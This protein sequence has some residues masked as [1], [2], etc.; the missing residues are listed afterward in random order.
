MKRT[1]L[2]LLIVFL[3][4]SCATQKKR[5][6]TSKIGKA[7]HNITSKYNRYFNADLLIDETIFQLE[8]SHQDNYNEILPVYPYMTNDNPTQMA[9]PMDRAIEKAS[10]AISLHRPSH[11]TDDNYHL[12]GKAQF[13][14]QDYES[15][16]AT[17]RYIVK[18]FDPS[19]IIKASNQGDRD[20]KQTA[21]ERAKSKKIAEKERQDKIKERSKAVSKNQSKKSKKA[22]ERSRQKRIK[23]R[24]E[25]IR[26]REKLA[27]KAD[28]K[29]AS[30]DKKE[31]DN[32]P[33]VVNA[34]SKKSKGKK[35]T[36]FDPNPQLPKIKGNPSNY[37]MKHK[38]IFQDAQLWL[39][40]T[41]IERDRYG[42]AENLLRILANNKNAFDH[43]QKELYVVQSHGYIKRGQYKNA[44]ES[45]TQATSRVD[46]KELRARYAFI[47]GQLQEDL[48]QNTEALASYDE[49]VKLR[50][51]YEMDFSARLRKIQLEWKTGVFPN[52]Q[53]V[54]NLKRM[55]KDEKNVEYRDQ[56]Y[57]AIAQHHLASNEKD[58]ALEHFKLSLASSTGNALQKAESYYSIANL[59]FGD[60]DYVNAKNY[61][62]STLMVLPETDDRYTDVKNY[63]KNLSGI[64]A[65]LEKIELQDSL[66]YLSTLSEKELKKIAQK[67]KKEQAAYAAQ[68]E[69]KEKTDNRQE[70]NVVNRGRSSLSSIQSSSNFFAYNEKSLKKGKRDFDRKW[71]GIQLRDNWRRSSGTS[72][73]DLAG[74]E[75]AQTQEG[76]GPISKTEIEEI[77]QAVPRS[78]AQL[79]AANRVIEEALFSLGRLFR[80]EL[81]N[82]QK[83]IESLEEM[84]KRYP[85][86]ENALD[87]YYLLYVSYKEENNKSKTDYYEEKILKEYGDSEYAKY[88]NDPSI[89]QNLETEED[90]LENF[91]Q[92]AFSL[93]ETGRAEDTRKMLSTSSEKFGTKHPLQSKFVFLDALCIGKTQGRE[94]YVNALKELIAKYPDTEEEKKAKEIIRLLGIRFTETSKGIQEINPDAYFQVSEKD[95][96]HYVLVSLREGVDLN[97]TRNKISD[98]NKKFHKLDK[99][100]MSTIVLNEKKTPLFVV[101]KFDSKDKAMVYYDGVQKNINEFGIEPTQF[102][103]FVATQVNYRKI[104]QAQSIDLYRDYFIK[105][106]LSN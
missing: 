31:D 4:S 39:A 69:Q 16:E 10:V 103:I 94:P 15:A 78:E 99:L 46:K 47:K 13:I 34:K 11:W 18:H 71:G 42:E 58:L 37:F 51:N 96:L 6:D 89:L 8:N 36:P 106:Y 93:F 41:L 21:K 40:K 82:N 43:I 14:K 98:Y 57:Y 86:S 20:R 105:S 56:I 2:F 7:Y 50:P 60:E 3:G 27:K 88:I 95:K 17:F 97:Q 68:A 100:T 55:A 28:T 65:N 72:F 9:E 19:N 73:G 64:A 25:Q 91:Y 70:L 44:V 62:D 77:F 53:Y 23:D 32:T 76:V 38:P 5:G 75:D 104:L 85:E 22:A 45:L 12:I 79:G 83:S 74:S 26:N 66:I 1:I 35:Q 59:Y 49:V 24:K 92:S 80:S 102:E 48:G 63:T 67:I 52:E 61:F 33:A 54:N 30:A 29:P 81:E 101:R 90:K 87:A 84:M